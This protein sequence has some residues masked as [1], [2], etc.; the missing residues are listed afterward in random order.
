[1][2]QFLFLSSQN[3]KM[4]RLQIFL[5]VFRLRRCGCSLFVFS[6]APLI[7]LISIY[8]TQQKSSVLNQLW[9]SSEFTLTER[10]ASLLDSFELC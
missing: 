5:T 2:F 7:A 10:A 4:N 3:H 6:H 9:R 1:M 8:L